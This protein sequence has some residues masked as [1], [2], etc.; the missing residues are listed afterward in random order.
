MKKIVLLGVMPLLL[1]NTATAR[2]LSTDYSMFK[3]WLNKNYGIDYGID[4]T[5]MPQRGAPNG[6]YNAFQ[7]YIYPYLTWT[8]FKNEYG[9]GQLNMAYTV[10]RYGNH[11]ASDIASNMGVVSSINDYDDK[12]NEFNELYYTYQLGGSWDW[13]TLGVGQFPIYNWDGSDYNS[14][15]QVNFINYALSQ[16]PSS[17]YSIAGVGGFATIAPNDEWSFTLGAQDASNVDGISVRVNDLSDGHFTTFGQIEW[18]PT[19]KLGDAQVSVLLYNQPGVKQQPQTTNGWSLNFSQ[20]IGEK[21]NIFARV[22]GVSGH[23]DTIEQS[24]S[25]GVVML[26]PLNRNSLDQIGFGYALNKINE[27]AVG[28]PLAHDKEHVFEAYWAWGFSKWMTLTPDVQFYIHPALNQKSDYGTAVSL[29]L[30][31]FL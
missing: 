16:N 7:T 4:V 20:N 29:R 19:N 27:T 5:L 31:L 26:N 14:N 10:V 6:E 9:T 15:Q 28:A 22:N 30:T 2:S 24:W 17:T 23:M 11:D 13:L 21:W 18:T 25:G 3:Y 8:T 1:A 12:T